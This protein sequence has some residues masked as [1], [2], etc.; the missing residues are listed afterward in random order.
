MVGKSRFILILVLILILDILSCSNAVGQ[1]R[2][3]A[4][5]ARLKTTYGDRLYLTY[6]PISDLICILSDG[7]RREYLATKNGE[8]TVGALENFLLPYRGKPQNQSIAFMVIEL[9]RPRAGFKLANDFTAGINP[10]SWSPDDIV[11]VANICDK[12]FMG[13]L[14]L[15]EIKREVASNTVPIDRA[16]QRMQNL[17]KNPYIGAESLSP[18]EEAFRKLIDQRPTEL[19]EMSN[20]KIFADIEAFKSKFDESIKKKAND[21]PTLPK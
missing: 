9:D 4:I 18:A 12:Y 14:A 15:Q 3:T 11:Q 13:Q 5:L 21:T 20:R 8:K 2:T 1:T 6:I 19:K 17:T 16:W 7:G 10:I